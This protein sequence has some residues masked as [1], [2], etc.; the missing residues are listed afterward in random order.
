MARKRARRAPPTP[1]QRRRMMIIGALLIA[2]ACFT[3]IYETVAYEGGRLL[4]LVIVLAV[5][6][7]VF[8]LPIIGTLRAARRKA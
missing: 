4:A 5:L 8:I 2:F 3:A 1:A 7:C 6:F